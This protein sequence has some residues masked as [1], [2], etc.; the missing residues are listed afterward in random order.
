MVNTSLPRADA[1]DLQQRMDDHEFAVKMRE[2]IL[3]IARA[4]A[5]RYGCKWILYILADEPRSK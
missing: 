1:C 3:I 4:L 2:G 5:K